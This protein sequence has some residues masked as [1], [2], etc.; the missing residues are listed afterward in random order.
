MNT[1]KNKEKR[2]QRRKQT[3]EDFTP[4]WLVDEMLDKLEEHSPDTFTDEE[5]T[6]LD[7]ACGNGN[8]LI[9]VIKRKLKYNSP[10]QAVS[11]IYGCDIQLDNIQECRL[12]ILKVIV[13][14]KKIKLTTSDY[15]EIIKQLVKNIVW[16]PIAKY[17]NGSLDYL[18]EKINAKPF[19]NYYSNDKCKKILD[20]IKRENK[21]KEIAIE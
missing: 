8:I 13:K 19:S 21:L 3:A 6:Y 2:K 10:I 9:Q 20:K 14:Y 7:P 12:R 1:D 16:T 4:L 18:D 11:T 15:C 17:K 5:K